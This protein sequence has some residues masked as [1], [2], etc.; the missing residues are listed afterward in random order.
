MTNIEPGTIESA[1][2]SP[3]RQRL[4]GIIAAKAEAEAAAKEAA[5]RVER[6]NALAGAT[7]P[8]EAE[9]Q[10]LNVKES[11]VMA[12][13]ARGDSCEPPPA[14]SVA[15][16]VDIERRLQEARA[17]ADAAQR[18]A[19]QMQNELA[20]ATRRVADIGRYFAPVI[21]DVVLEVLG[22]IVQAAREAVG[23]LAIARASGKAV[24]DLALEL[25]RQDMS[26]PGFG[27]FMER[28]TVASDGLAGAFSLP[29]DDGA[30]Y[31]EARAKLVRLEAALHG[32][33]NA[34]LEPAAN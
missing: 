1:P 6:L 7:A 28:F 8:I 32:D 17:T 30:A 21:A 19:A 33:A 11:A 20:D 9:L 29:L 12:A 16:R 4:A 2:L 3:A 15:A 34:T 31:I 25:A 14:A 10:A 22:P 24:L 27:A 5:A 23:C 13:W 18:A 26:A